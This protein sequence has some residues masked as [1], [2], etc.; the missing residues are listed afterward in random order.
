MKS[1]TLLVAALTLAA[2]SK[3]SGDSA[4]NN[5]AE[6][7]PAPAAPI[8]PGLFQQATTL[9]EFSD[10]NASK[11][12]ADAAAKAVGTTQTENRCVTADMVSDP[13]A[14]IQGDIDEGCAMQKTVWDAG[15]IDIALS[16]PSRAGSGTGQLA[17][18]GTYDAD[19]YAIAMTMKGPGGESIR[20]KVDAKR[21]GDC[22][23]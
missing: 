23:A 18:T 10:P 17:L 20:M 16:C 7:P 6:A 13:K 15:K 19:R 12:E 9:L 22:P 21:L 8:Q 3:E 5:V 1:H 2:C 14:L 11:A 4:A